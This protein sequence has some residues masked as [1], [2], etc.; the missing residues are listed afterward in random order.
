ML[1]IEIIISSILDPERLLDHASNQVSEGYGYLVSYRN[2]VMFTK[3]HNRLSNLI[4][5]L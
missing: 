3:E 1:F 5:K 2:S 4:H